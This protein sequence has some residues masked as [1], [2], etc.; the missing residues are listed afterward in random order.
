LINNAVFSRFV[1]YDD[2]LRLIP[3]LITEIPTESN[4]GISADHLRYTYHLNPQALWHDGVPLTSADVVF[5]WEIIMD[6]DA[7]AESQQGWDVIDRIDTPDEHTVVFHLREPY[8][9]FVEDTFYDEDVLPRHLLQ[10]A[11]GAAFARSAFHRHPVGSGPYR[12]VEWVAGSHITLR[13][14]DDWYGEGPYVDE[15]VFKVIPEVTALTLQL[16]AGE[17]D[18]CDNADVSQMEV[19]RRI[20]G[21]QVFETP[22]LAYTH[23]TLQC[24]HD[25]LGDVRVRRALSWATDRQAIADGVFDGIAEPAVSGKHPLSE[26]Y[27]PAVETLAT[28]DPERSRATLAAAGWVD[29]DGDGIREHDGDRLELEINT[30][31][32]RVD[33]ERIEAVL[34]QQ[35]KQIGVDLH[36]RN[37]EM[38]AL[39]ERLFEHEFDVALFGWTQQ[40][41]PGGIQGVYGSDGP[42]NFGRFENEEFDR[43]AQEGSVTFDHHKRVEIYRQMEWI[44]AQEVPA[45]PL[46]WH[47]EID[48]M[49]ERLHGFRPNPTAVGD[50]WNVHE[51]WVSR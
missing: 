43:L 51:W 2:S 19:L 32:G 15:L 50:T 22:S 34:Q 11:R 29:E 39:V 27:N 31:A 13:R 4:G 18:G 47:H 28:Y 44:L 37:L 21:M 10:D 5:T 45:I 12:F 35:W 17:I 36:I 25:I 41:D 7:G 46:V 33:R 16:R 49:T 40:P 30:G 48:V 14:F 23:L 3:D 9:N 20:P 38:N 24:R 42:Q 26:W 8:V 6:D 1:T